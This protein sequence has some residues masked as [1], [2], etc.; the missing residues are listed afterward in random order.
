[1]NEYNFY[2]TSSLLLRANDLFDYEE[3]VV[4]SSITLEELENIKSSYHKEIEQRQMAQKIL[5]R[6]NDNQDKF[7]IQIFKPEMLDNSTPISFRHWEIT[8]DIKI[9]ASAI[10]Y[11]CFRHPDETIFITNDLALKQIANC[12]F[13]QDSIKSIEIAPE[14]EYT[15]YREIVMNDDEMA[16]FYSNPNS[17]PYNLLTN[18]YVLIKNKEGEVE[19][20]MVWTGEVYRYLNSKPFDSKWFGKVGAYKNDIYQ[21]MA[22]DSLRNNQLTVL[23]GCPGSGKSY[24]GFTYLFSLLESGQIDKIYIFCNPVATRDSAKLG[25][26]PGDKNTKLMDSQ[27]GNFLVCKLGDALA[28]ESMISEGKIILVPAADCRGMD[29][30]ENSG[31]YITEAQNSTIDLMKLMLQ[32]IGENT[33]CVIEGDEKTQVDLDTYS[34]KNNGLKKLSQIFKG[35]DFYGEVRLNRCYRSRIATIAELM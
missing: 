13:G 12:Y 19:D 31:V 9:L 11:D 35:Q 7:E 8:N 2:D 32:R 6:L 15:G 14:E 20:L 30:A 17:N 3:N 34:G 28:V 29:I 5:K 21:K 4:I 22:I 24:L 33:K 25:F 23:R 18:E 27:I 16:D 10:A 1:M 26:Y